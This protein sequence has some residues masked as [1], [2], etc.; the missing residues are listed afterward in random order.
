MLGRNCVKLTPL[1]TRARSTRE[2]FY[3]FPRKCDNPRRCADAVSPTLASSRFIA[4]RPRRGGR[5]RTR[6][7]SEDELSA[8]T[9]PLR[10]CDDFPAAEIRESRD[11][12]VFV[13]NPER[14]AALSERGNAPFS[15][16]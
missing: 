10:L 3:N 4:D 11:I 15:E 9:A 7:R 5:E 8:K 6:T 12:R 16:C 14:R 2:F 1:Q 13:A